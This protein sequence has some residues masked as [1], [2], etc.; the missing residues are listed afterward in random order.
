MTTLDF[1]NCAKCGEPL[2]GEQTNC[3]MCGELL[4]TETVTEFEL[5]KPEDLVIEKQTADHLRFRMPSCAPPES[6]WKFVIPH[7]LGVGLYLVTSYFFLTDRPFDSLMIAILISLIPIF[8][9]GI[10]T[11]YILMGTKTIDLGPKWLSIRYA[12]GI[13]SFQKRLKTDRIKQV[14]IHM[15]KTSLAP[16]KCRVKCGFK[17]ISITDTHPPE[18]ARYITQL[19]RRQLKTMGHELADEA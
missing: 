2:E 19:I 7:F 11:T 17:V 13:F 8:V 5:P 4:S 6:R 15:V 12:I 3:P 10:T 14:F 16:E 1:F 18:T 9:L